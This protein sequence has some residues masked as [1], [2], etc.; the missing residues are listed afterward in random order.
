MR[1]CN[2]G[3][4]TQ[5]NSPDFHGRFKPLR[6]REQAPGYFATFLFRAQL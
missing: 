4:D 2:A 5:A 1:A 6:N 3:P